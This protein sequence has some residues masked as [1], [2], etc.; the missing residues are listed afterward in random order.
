[1]TAKKSGSSKGAAAPQGV[2]ASSGA[3]Q[4]AS[5]P[6]WLQQLAP[7]WGR[8]A[9]QAA[10]LM[11]PF[12]NAWA[13]AS[14]A[15]TPG[16]GLGAGVCAPGGAPTLPGL[17]EVMASFKGLKMDPERLSAIQADFL[18]EATQL[19]Q[20]AVAQAVPAP[21]RDR[22]FSSEAWRQPVAHFTAAW[23]LL[24]ATTL[25]RMAEAVEGDA[26]SRARIRFAV[27]QWV[28]AAAPSNF[29]ALNP[30]ALQKALE[31]KG[32]SLTA[33]IG[34]LLHDLKQGH[35]SQTDE[36]VFEVGRNVATSE[37][38]VVFEN[39]L[40]QL[41]EYKPLTEKVFERPML[42]VPPCINKFYILDLQPKNSLIRYTVEQG[43]RVFVVSWR[44][45][46]CEP[47]GQDLGRLHRR[48][49][50]QGD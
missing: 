36:S 33:G 25:M 44:N 47:C 10:P 12:V 18:R 34:L 7:M 38:A 48:R 50:H 14:Q 46:G 19:W 6:E 13:G 24:N 2:A 31:T 21:L 4:G 41:I 43:H 40:F 20:D 22:R 9:E 3:P 16:V 28:D 1:M 26:K 32:E 11:T 35:V 8:M 49:P 30:D 17:D 37:G 42:F 15:W 39:D 29:L 45:P 27:Q 5:S 23:Y